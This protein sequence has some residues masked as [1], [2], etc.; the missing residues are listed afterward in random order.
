MKL[1]MKLWKH[2]YCSN[3]PFTL[4][5]RMNFLRC[6]WLLSVACVNSTSSSL[7]SF[8]L[9]DSFASGQ[10]P[11]SSSNRSTFRYDQSSILLFL[12][13]VVVDFLVVDFVV[14]LFF[15]IFYRCSKQS[16]SSNQH[17]PLP[18][19][20]NHFSPPF[21]QSR[22]YARHFCGYNGFLG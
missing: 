11:R 15:F 13:V 19:S 20:G 3:Q 4:G 16:K 6:C 9:T 22:V 5:R 17:T 18:L 10:T 12:V 2:K 14:V 1:L 8:A 21:E 7:L